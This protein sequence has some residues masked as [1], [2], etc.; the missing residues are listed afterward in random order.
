M[1]SFDGRQR[2]GKIHRATAKHMVWVWLWPRM[3]GWWTDGTPV[4]WAQWLDECFWSKAN[5]QTQIESWNLCTTYSCRMHHHVFTA[6][7]FHG[8]SLLLRNIWPSTAGTTL[9]FVRNNHDWWNFRD[10]FEEAFLIKKGENC[11]YS[12]IWRVWLLKNDRCQQM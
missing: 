7:G 12:K 2:L 9:R 5:L 3:D 8:M 10:E 4:W 6:A 1:V 11:G